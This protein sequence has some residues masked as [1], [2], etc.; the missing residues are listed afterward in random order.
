M[1][2]HF[3]K[4]YRGPFRSQIRTACGWIFLLNCACSPTS[5]SI[6][7]E[8][9]VDEFRGRSG[10]EM[11]ELCRTINQPCGEETT[12]DS[13][14]EESPE[15]VFQKTTA[16]AILD[17]IAGRYP[18][19]HWT[20]QGDVINLGPKAKGHDNLL[21]TRISRI[22][23]HGKTSYTAARTVLS[24]AGIQVSDNYSG[25]DRVFARIDVELSNVTVRQALNATGRAPRT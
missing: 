19:H 4:L 17:A 16:R 13:S 22:S 20:I 11:F 18:A 1:I 7:L 6:S 5:A 15:L 10:Y 2:A 12:I 25:I 3:R 24:Q 9:P 14:R 23:I 8:V 21:E